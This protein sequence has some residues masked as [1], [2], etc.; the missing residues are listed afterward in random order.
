MPEL[1]EVETI[2]L[3]LL[4]KIKGKKIT[5]LEIRVPKLINLD[6]QNF[7]KQLIGAEINNVKRR[8]K[9]IIIELSNNKFLIIHLK[10]TGQLIYNGTE[11]KTTRAIFYFDN[12][13]KLIFN[14]WRKFGYFKLISTSELEKF[15]QKQNFGPEPLEKDFTFKKFQEILSKK[16]RSKIKPFLM[17]QANIAGLG[18]IYTDESLFDSQILPTRIINT[19]TLKEKKRLYESIKK[20]LQKAIKYQGSSV[21]AYLNACGEKGGFVPHLKVYRRTGEKCF[22]CGSIIKRTVLGGRSTHFCPSC[23]K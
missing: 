22:R 21:D 7:K 2:R 16:S 3:G 17:N 13:K 9:L 12:G 10:L 4:K 6:L 5:D 20:I 18:N 23:Q 14:D 19:L 8:A 15:L 11:E 1:P